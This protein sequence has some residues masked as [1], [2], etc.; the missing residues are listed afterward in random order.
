MLRS[1]SF[2]SLI[3]PHCQTRYRV[4]SE[5]IP[6][7]KIGSS[8][9][10]LKTRC[11][12]CQYIFTFSKKPETFGFP[13]KEKVP[14]A[15]HLAEQD[16]T[17]AVAVKTTLEEEPGRSH[18]DP[19]ASSSQAA[20]KENFDVTQ[21]RQARD[22]AS[23]PRSTHGDPRDRVQTGSKKFRSFLIILIILLTGLLFYGLYDLSKWVW[24]EVQ[25]KRLDIPR[26]G[27]GLSKK[28]P[29][30]EGL[31]A[32]NYYQKGRQYFLLDNEDGY[33]KAEAYYIKG[34]SLDLSDPTFL[35]AL[36]ENYVAWGQNR[37]DIELL[38]RG[39][40][41]AKK[42]LGMKPDLAE[43]YRV[44][45]DL[46][47]YHRQYDESEKMIKKALELKPENA[48][49]QYVLGS[50]TLAKGDNY[51]TAYEHLKKALD[52]NPDL[53]R[54]YADLTALLTDLEFYEE[55]ITY[56][57]K[58]LELSPEHL[59]L[60]INLGTA[61]KGIKDYVG[62]LQIYQ[63]LVEVRP[64]HFQI[65][66][67][68][69]ELFNTL[70]NYDNALWYLTQST[71]LNPYEALGYANLGDSY[72][73]KG[74][75][76]TAIQMY[77][78]AIQLSPQTA[79]Y[80]YKLGDTYL[81]QRK[82]ELVK[83]SYQRGL[84]LDRNK[85]RY[86]MAM[87]KMYREQQLHQLALEAYQ[88]AFM[89]QSR[90]KEVLEELVKTYQDLNRIE[91]ARPYQQ[92]LGLPGLEKISRAMEGGI[93]CLEK[94]AYSLAILKFQ[95]V[96]ELDKNYAQAYYYLGKTYELSGNLESALNAY[97]VS[98]KVP[99]SLPP[100]ARNYLVNYVEAHAGDPGISRLIDLLKNDPNPEIQ[101]K[102]TELLRKGK[103]PGS[104]SN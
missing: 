88:R 95:E 60:K 40:Q 48:D 19:M 94:K 84:E 17:E 35:A 63:Q 21:S 82:F 86:Y 90:N 89:L 5:K 61:Y 31:T 28:F 23:S 16:E 13:P 54:A 15:P 91:D 101:A 52:L 103:I 41:L 77:Q 36:A 92:L 69:G 104:V 74:D 64:R 33:S 68:L 56:A 43:G 4:P 12:K 100:E 99:D 102:I 29:V 85:F 93:R 49:S 2:I 25:M 22:S 11:L 96:L 62:A 73:G 32:Q 44:I 9:R 26:S 7:D 38:E 20:S 75:Y 81:K 37:E 58:G 70:G 47:K 45:A 67:R 97:V 42:A 24:V 65:L 79:I 51:G 30:E 59:R 34:I 14:R 98:L 46:L 10:P 72:F 57:R 1:K 50:L 76:K 66:N 71:E 8:N 87:G 53:V 55:A 3:C 6:E 78:K 18:F 27:V 83:S 80:P 39:Y